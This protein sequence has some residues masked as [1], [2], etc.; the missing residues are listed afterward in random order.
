MG[1]RGYQPEF[2][3]KVGRPGRGGPLSRRPRQGL[4]IR[5]QS[6]STW[7]RQD[8][9]GRGLVFRQPE[10]RAGQAVP[11]HGPPGVPRPARRGPRCDRRR[12]A[13]GRPGHLTPAPTRASSSASPQPGSRPPPMGSICS[14]SRTA[15]RLST[16]A[17]RIRSASSCNL[18][19]CPDRPP[20]PSGPALRKIGFELTSWPS[21]TSSRVRWVRPRPP[22]E[23]N[24]ARRHK[25]GRE[26]PTIAVHRRIGCGHAPEAAEGVLAG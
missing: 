17:G 12:G 26:R 20:P 25:S 5:E 4:G 16:G 24:S 19:S 21:R 2:R 13:G 10:R 14:G 3:R 23:L 11:W 15:G 6:I 1:R 22:R 7:R 8:R 9:I 18:A